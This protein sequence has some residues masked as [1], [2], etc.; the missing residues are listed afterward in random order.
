MTR[1]VEAYIGEYNSGKSEVAINR[2]LDLL[3]EDRKVTL[4]DLDIVEP[5]YTLRPLK[6]KL[7]E[8]GLTILAWETK[9]TTGLGEAGNIIK[10]EMKW[11]LRREGD[12]ILDIGYGVEGAKTLNLVEEKEKYPELRIY[13]VVN[14]GRPI[15][16]DKDEIVEYVQTLGPVHGVINNSHLGDETDVEFVQ[17]GARVI[18]A[19]ARE[20]GLPVIA[21]TIDYR[22]ADKIGSHDCEGNPVRLLYRYMDRSFW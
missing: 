20:I 5:F 17:E 7:Q 19:A 15:T 22:L 14:I 4:V 3:K 21:T 13:A 16:S 9:E 11:A 1:I 2:A 12:V 8:K 6:K 10:P 18:G